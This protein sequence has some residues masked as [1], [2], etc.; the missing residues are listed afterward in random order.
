MKEEIPA[1]LANAAWGRYGLKG[2]IINNASVSAHGGFPGIG[3]YSV[4]KHGVLGLTRG[5]AV[6]YGKDAYGSSRYRQAASTSP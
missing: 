5:A 2:V 1:M 3:P 4:S 6:D